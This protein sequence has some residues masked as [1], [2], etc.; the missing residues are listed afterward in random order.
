MSYRL[1]EITGFLF[2]DEM[3]NPDFESV[4][5]DLFLSRE[6]WVDL[7]LEL[8]DFKFEGQNFPAQ[9]FVFRKDFIENKMD[10]CYE[11]K[12]FYHYKISLMDKTNND[13]YEAIVNLY[14]G[15]PTDIEI[16]YKGKS[17]KAD[18]CNNKCI[19]FVNAK[20]DDTFSYKEDNKDWKES[21]PSQ[22]KLGSE[23]YIEF[24]YCKNC[25]KI[26]F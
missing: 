21:S 16:E 22:L 10:E 20:C 15:D 19:I 17:K 8:P 6:D 4:L 9:I 23:D 1:D 7:K 25:S 12:S 14:N 11:G 13:C 3:L 5:Y 26:Q 2:N 18:C 24:K